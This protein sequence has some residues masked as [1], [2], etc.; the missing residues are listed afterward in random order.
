M[1]LNWVFYLKLQPASEVSGHVDPKIP[2]HKTFLCVCYELHV[3]VS[4]SQSW[5][6]KGT[7]IIVPIIVI[8][9]DILPIIQNESGY[10]FDLCPVTH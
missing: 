2:H 1:V 6:N 8:K 3:S 7:G 4:S 5:E 9:G 10:R